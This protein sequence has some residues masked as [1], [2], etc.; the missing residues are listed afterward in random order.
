MH[1]HTYIHTSYIHVFAL[2]TENSPVGEVDRLGRVRRFEEAQDEDD[3]REVDEDGL[4]M[5]ERVQWMGLI[6]LRSS[7]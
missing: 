4:R 2:T 7:F 1:T 3:N 5:E 6:R